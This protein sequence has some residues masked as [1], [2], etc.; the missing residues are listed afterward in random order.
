M[1]ISLAPTVLFHIGNFPVTN[2]LWV[3]FFISFGLIS[4]F[5]FVAKTMKEVPGT[6]QLYVEE[7]VLYCHKFVKESTGGNK[8]AQ[9][10]FPLFT[11]LAIFFL[12]ANL[13]PYLPGLSAITYNDMPLYRTA[14]ADYALIFA[15]TF[16]I[17]VVIQAV[18]IKSAGL[19]G[20]FK[21]FI[22]FS[23]PMDF[24]MGILDIIG[25]LAK[26]VSLS[27][28][29]FGNVFAG[30]VLSIILLSLLPYV[31]PVPM[32]LLTL[33]SAVIQAFVFPI[34]VLIYFT[35]V[36]DAGK[37]VAQEAATN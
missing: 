29:L 36:M 14:T 4:V 23:S 21:K 26:I 24:I 6:L 18:A 1:D 22:N 20:Y 34:L 30:E 19:F 12:T 35:M 32:A 13:L 15:I 27:F 5:Y 2:S 25:E 7:F 31:A 37:Q 10:L 33:L 9:W 17:F 8:A 16:S 3:A 11:T 28:R